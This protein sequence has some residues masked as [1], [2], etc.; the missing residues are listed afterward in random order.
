MSPEV[1][2]DSSDI[3]KEDIRVKQDKNSVS[4]EYPEDMT[5]EK[6]TEA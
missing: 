6:V 2:G 4:M 5:P 3:N 1:R